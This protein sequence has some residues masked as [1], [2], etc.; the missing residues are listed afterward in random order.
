LRPGRVHSADGWESVLKPVVARYKGRVSRI[1]FR[2][3][4]GFAN[5]D[6]YGCA[7][8][9]PLLRRQ[10]RASS[11][12]RAG[13]QPRHFLRTL[14]TPEPIKEWSLT[15]LKEKLL[16]IGAKVVSHGRGLQFS[17]KREPSMP[18]GR[19]SGESRL[20]APAAWQYWPR[21]ASA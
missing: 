7:L 21:S 6:I 8:V 4:A 19:S 2:G 3:D 9:M 10:G 12:S 18:V 5:P 1:Y 14:A 20:V 11:A 15:T 17:R 13:L 16:K